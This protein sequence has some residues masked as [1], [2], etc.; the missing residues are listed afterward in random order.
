MSKQI[1]VPENSSMKPINL[2][3]N[4]DKNH[5]FLWFSVLSNPIILYLS[6]MSMHQASLNITGFPCKSEE[7]DNITSPTSSDQKRKKN[8]CHKTMLVM[9]QRKIVR[10]YTYLATS[11][12]KRTSDVCRISGVIFARSSESSPG[13]TY[14]HI[15]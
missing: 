15:A 8:T 6:K 10:K 14:E 12:A 11:R 13:S 3:K 9:L 5:L 7:T 2:R 1:K 4:L